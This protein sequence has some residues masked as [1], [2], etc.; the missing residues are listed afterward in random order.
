MQNTDTVSETLRRPTVGFIYRILNTRRNASYI[1]STVNPAQRWKT[2]RRDLNA[3]RH[4]NS[5]LQRS[6]V[7]YGRAAFRF[8]IVA[9]NVPIDELHI[10]EDAI[11]AK[12]KSDGFTTY[13]M[14]PSAANC[15][16]IKRSAEVCRAISARMKGRPGNKGFR[17][18]DATKHK[19]REIRRRQ[20]PLS[21]AS[22]AKIAAANTGRKHTAATRQKVS[23]ALTGK[24]RTD[25]QRERMRLAQAGVRHD[26]NKGRK[27]GQEVRDKIAAARRGQPSYHRSAETRELQSAASKAAWQRRREAGW[28]RRPDLACCVC[29]RHVRTLRRGRCGACN[30]YLRRCGIE[31]PPT[32]WAN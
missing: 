6:W 8:E 29:A 26:H 30:E 24:K 31:R 25:E 5:R 22:R 4:F 32:L 10:V 27:F 7:K 28:A 15:A 13:N 20:A 23:Q 11:I 21:A 12:A 17:H 3:G 14:T 9:D 1:G 16:G 19:L 2:H 18:T